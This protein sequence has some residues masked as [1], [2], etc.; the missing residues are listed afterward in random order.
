MAGAPCH[1][2]INLVIRCERGTAW[3]AA[4]IYQ[5]PDVSLLVFPPS[6]TFAVFTTAA[7]FL[8]FPRLLPRPS[9]V[10]SR[11][12]SFSL[13]LSPSLSFRLLSRLFSIR[14]LFR[15]ATRTLASYVDIGSLV[16]ARDSRGRFI[17]QSALKKS[18]EK[19]QDGAK[20]PK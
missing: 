6:L 3:R 4:Y 18:Q 13:V 17:K 10:R 11:S 16:M 20:E 5:P 1:P 14:F 12:L 2:V 15:L 19:D 7:T 9:L 8:V